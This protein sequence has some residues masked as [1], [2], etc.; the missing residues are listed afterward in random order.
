MKRNA[1]LASLLAVGIACFMLNFYQTS[2][3]APKKELP[4][5]NAVQQRLDMINELK[6]IATLL[7]EQNQLLKKQNAILQKTAAGK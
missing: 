1:L 4:F 5:P 2:Q 6:G 3:A 7:R